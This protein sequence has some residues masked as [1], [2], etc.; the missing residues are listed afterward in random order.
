MLDLSLHI[1][2][3]AT[4]SVFA[5]AN[6]V[7]I[8]LTL[9]EKNSVLKLCIVDDGNGMS[10]NEA[11]HVYDPF[12]STKI[13]H[14][15]GLGIPLLKQRAEL[16]GGNC[17]VSSKQGSGTVVCATFNTKSVDFVP[18]GDVASTIAVLSI[19]NP[20]VD[21]YYRETN[22]ICEFEF[23]SQILREANLQIDCDFVRVLDFVSEY[24]K[25]YSVL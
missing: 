21:F 16:T 3:I 11:C 13:G 17:N 14:K 12:Y 22:D 24:F 10:Q 5:G 15:V 1:L 18:L 25:E 2:D 4:N 7:E 19:T 20:F 9:D 6:R 8:S 23:C